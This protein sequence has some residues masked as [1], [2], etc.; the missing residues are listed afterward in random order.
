MPADTSSMYSVNDEVGEDTNN[1]SGVS[2]SPNTATKK[3][4]WW[5]TPYECVVL[6]AVCLLSV[7]TNFIYDFP[8][9]LGMGAGDT[10]EAR[11]EF[12]GHDY[13]QAMNQALYASYS[14][15][16]TF[17][18]ILGG[19]LLDQ[20]F[21]LRRATCIFTLT[22]LTGA[23]LFYFGVRCTTYELMITG[24]VILGIGCECVGISQSA[25]NVRW[26]KGKS[27][28]ALAFG[29]SIAFQRLGATLNFVCS[30]RI[31]TMFGVT[32]AVFGGIVSCCLS[33]IVSVALMMLDRGG[34]A[35]E[36]VPPI[37]IKKPP[38]KKADDINDDNDEDENTNKG[39]CGPVLRFFKGVRSLPLRFWLLQVTCFS[40]YTSL[41]PFVGVAQNMI[42]RV[43]TMD[44]VSAASIVSAFQIISM[45]GSPFAGVIVDRVGR[46]CCFVV[47]AASIVT[48]S[49]VFWLVLPVAS[50]PPIV[51][52][53]LMGVGYCCVAGSLFPSVPHLVP[54]HQLGIAYG[55]MTAGIA[56]FGATMRII[57][58]VVLDEYPGAD[59]SITVI[60]TNHSNN[61]AVVS[62]TTVINPDGPPLPSARGFQHLELIFLGFSCLALAASVALLLYDALFFPLEKRLNISR[63]DRLKIREEAQKLLTTN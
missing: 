38:P 3:G 33:V 22:T 13:T 1:G 5:W 42:Q 63:A 43:Y 11:Y 18:T 31:A 20:Y 51:V 58:G 40:F 19:I 24:R 26:F 34:E 10:I 50:V 41:L 25:W 15:P 49:H 7:G 29:L 9:V 55:C 21:G 48:L 14:Y 28:M 6:L 16:N 45:C 12:R 54:T 60:V 56:V 44:S 62:N 47:A 30:P 36:L 59:T 8:G 32:N 61:N 37:T 46:L 2:P 39:I 57:C 27:G 23:I 35:R 17:M 4:C 52:I 53:L